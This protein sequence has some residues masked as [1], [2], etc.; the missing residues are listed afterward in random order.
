M[1]EQL[2]ERTGGGR[3]K[4]EWGLLSTGGGELRWR[5]RLDPQGKRRKKK[6]NSW[7]LLSGTSSPSGPS[8]PSFYR[9]IRFPNFI[10]WRRGGGGKLAAQEWHH[11]RLPGSAFQIAEE[12]ACCNSEWV[13][14]ELLFPCLI[15]FSYQTGC[16][17]TS[18]FFWPFFFPFFVFSL[19]L[20]LKRVENLEYRRGSLL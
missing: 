18:W 6:A 2:G 14:L 7:S 15:G 4:D 10:L 16:H 1:W 13:L 8:P 17:S 19:F 20:R 9:R 5:Q 11:P 12:S 3:G